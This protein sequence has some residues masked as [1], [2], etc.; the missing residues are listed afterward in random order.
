M[1]LVEKFLGGDTDRVFHHIY[2]AAQSIRNLNGYQIDKCQ[3]KCCVQLGRQV[4]SFRSPVLSVPVIVVRT[5]PGATAHRVVLD[6]VFKVERIQVFLGQLL[7][8]T[9]L[10][11][12]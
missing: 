2:C 5:E 11:S 4:H 9:F 8:E 10:I 3:I 6:A 1:P 7:A 12:Q